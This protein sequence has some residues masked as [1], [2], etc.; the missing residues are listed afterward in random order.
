MDPDLVVKGAVW[1]LAIAFIV[2]G[3]AD[4]YSGLHGIK[5]QTVSEIILEF[6][7]RYPMAVFAVG[8][9]TGHLIWPQRTR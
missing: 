2:A 6:S 9:L 8:M 1:L 3:L 5:G 4:L 7:Q